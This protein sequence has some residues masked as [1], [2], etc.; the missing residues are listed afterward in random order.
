[1]ATRRNRL[2]TL[3]ACDATGQV[4]THR[5]HGSAISVSAGLRTAYG[6]LTWSPV[7]GGPHGTL[8]VGGGELNHRVRIQP[9]Y[10]ITPTDSWHWGAILVGKR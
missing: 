8:T 9:R 6:D 3:V 1:M 7:I 10:R 5:E 2:G 4:V